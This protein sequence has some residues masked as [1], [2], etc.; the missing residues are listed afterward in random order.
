MN[1]FLIQHNST[2]IK[3]K[4]ST[5]NN[6]LMLSYIPV[7]LKKDNP[8]SLILTIVLFLAIE[9]FV[10]IHHLSTLYGARDR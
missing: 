3:K 4:F 7:C 10:K 2:V 9:P 1:T 8:S 6:D 5:I